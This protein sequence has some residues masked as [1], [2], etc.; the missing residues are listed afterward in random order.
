V[1]NQQSVGI[2]YINTLRVMA[3]SAVI[4]AHV[5]RW[6]TKSTTVF[7]GDWW[8]GTLIYYGCFWT[9]PV[10][11][12]VSGALLLDERRQDGPLDFYK[13][14]L[15]RIGIPL[16]FWTIFYLGVRRFMRGE[17]LSAAY[18]AELI[19]NATPY[20]HLWFLYMILGLYLITPVARGFVHHVPRADRLFVIALIMVLADAYHL[21]NV[22]YLHNQRTLFTL[23]V[24]YIG[25][26][27]LGH[28]LQSLKPQ[29]VSRTFWVTAVCVSGIHILCLAKPFIKVSGWIGEE[30]VFSFFSPAV[31]L[32]S[33]GIFWS[34]LFSDQRKTSYGLFARCMAALAPATLGIYVLH[35]FILEMMGKLAG[36]Q[37]QQTSLIASTLMGPVITYIFCYAV[38]AVLMKIPYVRRMVC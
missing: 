34:A 18:V 32:V 12:M 30:P 17:H 7:S 28:E 20:F 5:A 22:F 24:P 21:T 36:S 2:H 29:Q 1:S 19:L 31:C 27:L 37:T 23:F 3:V 35:F 10:F 14:R 16:I 4:L 26:Y 13:R 15:H 33:V 25:Y 9:M 11:V 6:V 38:V 8:F